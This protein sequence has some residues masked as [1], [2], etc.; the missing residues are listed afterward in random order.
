[1]CSR[2]WVLQLIEAMRIRQAAEIDERANPLPPHQLA[3]GA[4]NP[5]VQGAGAFNII[6]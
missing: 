1:M 4:D 3:K 6:G 5:I 2:V